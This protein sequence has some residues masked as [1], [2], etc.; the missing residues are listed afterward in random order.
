[1]YTNSGVFLV[2][3]Y[4]SPPESCI[5]ISYQYIKRFFFSLNNY[6][7]VFI[8]P[9]NAFGVGELDETIRPCSF[10]IGSENFNIA[11]QCQQLQAKVTMEESFDM[12]GLAPLMI[13][14]AHSKQV[15]VV[16]GCGT[17]IL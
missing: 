9:C 3:F 14:Q 10:T 11:I 6:S 4:R 5:S 13:P 12:N 1:M 15:E 17:T 16:F 8:G 7:G 2:L